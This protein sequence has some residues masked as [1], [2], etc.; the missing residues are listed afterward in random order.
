ML[1]VTIDTAMGAEPAV[2]PIGLPMRQVQVHGQTLWVEI[3]ESDDAL[4][5]GLSKRDSLPPDHGMLFV[6]PRV[7]PMSFWMRNTHM[8][9]SIAF[10]DAQG[11]IL[12]IQSMVPDRTDILYRSPGPV[13]YAVEV[14]LGWFAS[15][16]VNVGDRFDLTQR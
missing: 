15:H 12:D 3:A 11:R 2:C 13:R 5:C 1:A 7:M 14:N 8:P 4:L 9:L 10:L 16:G 6:M